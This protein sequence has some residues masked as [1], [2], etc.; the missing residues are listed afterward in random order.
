MKQSKT[1]GIN[2]IMS[3]DYV[4]NTKFRLISNEITNLTESKSKRSTPLVTSIVLKP[5]CVSGIIRNESYKQ[6]PLAQLSE[7]SG[8]KNNTALLQ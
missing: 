3:F 5:N 6:Y 7:H 8:A 2:I 1:I 4:I